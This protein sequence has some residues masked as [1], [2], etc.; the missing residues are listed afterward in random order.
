[1]LGAW[2]ATATRD[3][4]ETVHQIHED[5][6][7]VGAEIAT[8][9][10]FL[11]NS[12]KLGLVGLGEK[13]AAYTRLAGEIAVAARERLRPDAYVAGGMALPRGGRA[14]VDA[15]DLP[16]EFAMQALALKEAGV[17]L[18]LLEYIGHVDDV[19]AAIDAVKPTGLPIMVGVRHVREDGSMQQVRPTISS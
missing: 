2:S 7:N 3:A 9:N 1:M 19:T 4:S 5:Y 16:K 8:T 10:S 17:D 6:F 11:T 18:L 15:V 12:V 13:A 14:P